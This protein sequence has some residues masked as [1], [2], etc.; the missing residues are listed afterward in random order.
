M[1]EFQGLNRLTRGHGGG[2]PGRIPAAT[3]GHDGGESFHHRKA[4]CGYLCG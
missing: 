4:K 3:W 2:E 1:T